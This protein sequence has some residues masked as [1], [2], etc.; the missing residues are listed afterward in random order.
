ME[1]TV[2]CFSSSKSDIFPSNTLSS[3]ENEILDNELEGENLKIGLSTIGVG[4]IFEDIVIEDQEP[5]FISNMIFS[6]FLPR[7]L[8]FTLFFY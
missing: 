5:L 4:N 7:I 6:N 2:V 1:Q 3:F 8:I